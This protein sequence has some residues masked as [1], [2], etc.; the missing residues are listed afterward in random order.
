VVGAVGARFASAASEVSHHPCSRAVRRCL[1]LIGTAIRKRG[2]F[3][4]YMVTPCYEPVNANDPC[5]GC[6]NT[7]P[8]LRTESSNGTTPQGCN[9][10]TPCEISDYAIIDSFA[11]L[12]IGRPTPLQRTSS[13]T[14]HRPR[15][16]RWED[17]P[18]TDESQE[19]Q[20]AQ[21]YANWH[22]YEFL[23]RAE[24]A[25]LVRNIFLLL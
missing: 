14:S 1:R 22:F 24:I 16:F 23:R 2:P 4:S 11:V 21:V 13:D 5:P 7:Q 10:T 9:A 3:T 25:N 6:G 15:G 8:W 18:S 20:N 17:R 12:R 19:R